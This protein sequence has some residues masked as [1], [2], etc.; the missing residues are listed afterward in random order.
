[1]NVYEHT[2]AV[3]TR[4]HDELISWASSLMKEAG[5]DIVDVWGR[6]PPE[7]TTRSHLVMFPYRVGPDPKLIDNVPSVSLLAGPARSEAR[8]RNIPVEW[9]DLGKYLSMYLGDFYPDVAPPDPKRQFTTSPY[10]L[11]EQVPEPLATWYRAQK[12]EEDGSGWVIEDEAGLH[13]RPP[14]L[15]WHTGIVVGAYYICVAGDPGR[16]TA[17]TTSDS[18]PLALAALSVLTMGVQAQRTVK[19]RLPPRPVPDE[20]YSFV[21]AYAE[22]AK[23]IPHDDPREDPPGRMLEIAKILHGESIGHFEVSPVHD[24]NN[25][26][27][28][29]LAQALQRPLQ[30][31]LNFRLRIPVGAGPDFNPSSQIV[32]AASKRDGKG[33]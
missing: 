3:T 26:E 23:S 32:V 6:F 19:V 20:F 25:S 8:N 1:M 9:S 10:P 12:P 16:G 28:A 7:G 27:F 21:D 22:T 29:T 24:M 33:R 31:F 5:L 13:C 2:N 4:V 30:A 14:S 17:A 11:A 15:M 18:A